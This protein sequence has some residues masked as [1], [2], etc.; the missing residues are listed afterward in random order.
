MAKKKEPEPVPVETLSLEIGDA[1]AVLGADDVLLRLEPAQVA[2]L[3][4]NAAKASNDLHV[5]SNA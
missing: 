2:Y 5:P 3:A 1:H 4:K